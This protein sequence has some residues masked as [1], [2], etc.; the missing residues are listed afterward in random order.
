MKWR[1]INACARA[2]LNFARVIDAGAPKEAV[3]LAMREA[4]ARFI[5]ENS[6]KPLSAPQEKGN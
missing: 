3:Q 2:I 4:V 1:F 6:K 5:N